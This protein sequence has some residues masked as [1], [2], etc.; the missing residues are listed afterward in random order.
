[1]PDFGDTIENTEDMD[2]D[3]LEQITGEHW[4]KIETQG[5][6]VVMADDESSWRLIVNGERKGEVWQLSEYGIQRLIKCNFLRMLELYLS[7][8]LMEFIIECR[9]EEYPQEPDLTKQCKKV[10]KKLRIEMNPPIDITEIQEF[11]ERHNILLPK[12]ILLF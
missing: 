2:E 3:T 11:E 4:E 9:D 8:G 10:I 12:S 6:I 1:M 7:G 5:N